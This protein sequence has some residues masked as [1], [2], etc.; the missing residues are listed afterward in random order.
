MWKYPCFVQSLTKYNLMLIS[1]YCHFLLIA[2]IVMHVTEF[3]VATS[4]Y[5]SGC[6]ISVKIVCMYSLFQQFVNWVPILASIHN[7]STVFIILNFIC[8]Y[9]FVYGIILGYFSY[10]PVLP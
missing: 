5:G 6:S 9:P 7:M 2:L 3:Y 4:V 10:F 8:N 1:L